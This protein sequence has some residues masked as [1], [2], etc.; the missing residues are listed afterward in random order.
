MCWVLPWRF[1][2]GNGIQTKCGYDP[3][4]EGNRSNVDAGDP[5]TGDFGDAKIIETFGDVPA[6]L[7]LN[8]LLA[9]SGQIRSP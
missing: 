8:T 2:N 6:D 5:A 3:Y 7:N 1:A 4:R 9:F